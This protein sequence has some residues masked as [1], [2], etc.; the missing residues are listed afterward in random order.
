[1]SVKQ[2][3][4]DYLRE[5]IQSKESILKKLER[6][7]VSEKAKKTELENLLLFID[8]E[9]KDYRTVDRQERNSL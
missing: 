7:P 1:M 6:L 4:D 8:S 5:L 9:I 3:I 2:I